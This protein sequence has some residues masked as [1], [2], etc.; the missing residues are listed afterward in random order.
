MKNSEKIKAII[1]ELLA[2]THI[3]I[4]EKTMSK[5][6]WIANRKMCES[7]NVSD[8]YME[9]LWLTFFHYSLYPDAS[10]QLSRQIDYTIRQMFIPVTQD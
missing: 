4:N 7:P 8:A 1:P 10:P 9:Y 6:E 3:T 2:A 5:E